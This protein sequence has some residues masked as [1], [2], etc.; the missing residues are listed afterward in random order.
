[1]REGIRGLVVDGRHYKAVQA[2]IGLAVGLGVM[3][4]GA[5]AHAATIAGAGSVTILRPL[6]V[7]GSSGIAF[8][9]LHNQGPKGPDGTVTV[10]SAPPATRTSTGSGVQLLPGTDPAPAIRSLSGEPSR[11]YRVTTP[12]SVTAS[13]G[14]LLV[15]QFTVWSQNSGN[16][17]TG[18]IGQLNASGV[19]TVR[20]GGTLTVPAGTKNDT[21]TATVPVTLSYD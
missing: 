17:T 1:M 14:G 4:L 8:G 16:I 20:V 21:Y 13:P 12:A 19:D 11:A 9:K 10:S 6:S 18:R 3:A 15:N 2:S 5:A 7:S